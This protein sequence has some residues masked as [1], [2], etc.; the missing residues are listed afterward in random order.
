[1]EMQAAVGTAVGIT[2]LVTVVI[3]RLWD[4]YHM[5]K[6]Y[7]TKVSSGACMKKREDAEKDMCEQLD[8]ISRRLVLGNVI[9]SK[10]AEKQGLS[11]DIEQWEK[12]LG[13]KLKDPFYTPKID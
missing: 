2:G 9:M 12:A 11:S 10:L 13:L 3:T 4:A 1:M 6:K 7:Q 5:E 8:I